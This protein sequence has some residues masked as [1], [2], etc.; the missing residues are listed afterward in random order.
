MPRVK[1][2]RFL[3]VGL[4]VPLLCTRASATWSIVVANSATGEVGVASAT[5]LD[6]FNLQTG[7]GVIVVGRGAAQSQSFLDPGIARTTMFTSMQLGIPAQ[8]ILAY[9]Q[10]LSEADPVLRQWG[11][12]TL[13][14]PAATFTGGASGQWAGGVVGQ[15]GPISYAIQ[16]NVLTC[17]SVIDAAEEALIAAP[18]DL[19]QK[20]MAA[21]QAAKAAGGDGRCSCPCSPTPCIPAPMAC[22]CPPPPTV[23]MWKSAHVGYLTIARIGDT[24]GTCC[25]DRDCEDG[26][27]NGDYYLDLN[28]A[29]SLGSVSSPDPVDTLQ[30]MY[31]AFR[32]AHVGHPDGILSTA[33]AAVPN[34]PADGSSQTTLT[35]ALADI[36]GNPVT[37]GGATVT[38]SHDAT[39]AGSCSIGPVA[40]LGNGTYQVT[41]TAGTIA[42]TD[43][44][45]VVVGDPLGPVTLYPHATLAVR[46]PGPLLYEVNGEAVGHRL[47]SAVCPA[48]HL[49]GDAASDFVVGIPEAS[50]AGLPFAGQARVFSG[51]GGT[52]LS[53]PGTVEEGRLGSSLARLGDIDGDGITD[54]L[55]GAPACHGGPCGPGRARAFSGSDGST[56]LTVTGTVPEELFGSAVSG[57]GDLD[58]DG[59]PDFL[60]GAPGTG[61]GSVRAFS[62]VD[63]T[64]LRLWEGAVPGEGFGVAVASTGDADGD[65]VREVLVGIP[66]A[67][68]GGAVDAGLVRVFSGGTGALLRALGGEQSGEQLGSSVAS[69]GRVD[70]DGVEDWIAG[71]PTSDVGTLLDAG[72]ARIFSGATGGVLQVLEGGVEA[73]LLGSAVTGLPDVNGDVRAEVAVGSAGAGAGGEVT[74]H[75][76]VNGLLLLTVQGL[77]GDL[78]GK[79]LAP[80]GDVDGDGVAELLVGAP[81][82]DPA[83][84]VDAGQA[85]VYSLAGLGGAI[86]VKLRARI[87]LQREPEEPDADASGRVEVRLKGLDQAFS[88][89]V[90]RLGPG[91]PFSAFL[92]EAE[93]SGTFLSI[94]ELQAPS[95]TSQRLFLSLSSEGVPPAQLGV[96]LLSSLEGRR[97]EVRDGAGVSYLRARLPSL[98]GAG[99]LRRTGSLAPP[100]ASVG[101]ASGTVR[102]GR[103]GSKGIERFD[104]RAK[105]LAPGPTYGVW[106]ADA[107]RGGSFSAAGDLAKGKL[108]RD[109]GR[110]DPL[111]LG[112]DRLEELA[113]RAIEIR[114]GA[115]VVL[116]GT[117]P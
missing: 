34:L 30:T 104:V 80:A 72:R 68:P 57:A 40:D 65:G 66:G 105:G 52:L 110:G 51:S 2:P 5:C 95:P 33:A 84:I 43:V 7:A 4:L 58:G 10:A 38:V 100:S 70:A 59:I 49:D 87:A 60:V 77:A 112:V 79:A 86:P 19:G 94:G 48:G 25:A 63:G 1:R 115:T 81:G 101:G 23:P 111:P 117:I 21:M 113:G 37:T 31:D 108:R 89:E 29:G 69:A 90:R 42:G 32:A 55:A 22:G 92:E 36:D 44:F 26:C 56:L 83:G 9:L 93:G 16:G 17:Q 116:A 99:D 91:S 102:L 54:L 46:A 11:I 73:G 96:A 12:A 98:L 97:L 76:G 8:S 74:V 3:L 20:M 15:V 47:G 82:A 45:R 6:L 88:V 53:H 71:A 18:G 50:P 28:V 14:A 13:G 106:I 61:A 24:D 62:G 64:S 109:T 107:G 41:L 75:S 35:I 78:V 114:D 103:K 85:R 27:A 67:D 39:S